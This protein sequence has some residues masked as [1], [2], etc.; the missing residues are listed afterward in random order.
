MITYLQYFDINGDKQYFDKDDCSRVIDK[1]TITNY[2]INTSTPEFDNLLETIFNNFFVEFE[3]YKKTQKIY[4]NS[5]NAVNA[6]NKLIYISGITAVILSALKTHVFK[7]EFGVFIK[8]S[9][10]AYNKEILASKTKKKTKPTPLY[11]KGF[12]FNQM[13]PVFDILNDLKYIKMYVGYNNKITANKKFTCF[14]NYYPTDKLIKL[15][16]KTPLPKLITPVEY[17][18]PLKSL[19]KEPVILRDNDKNDMKILKSS[20]IVKP[21]IRFLDKFNKFMKKAKISHVQNMFQW[22]HKTIR[23][24]RVFNNSSWSKGGR[25]YGAYQSEN[26]QNNQRQNILI[27]GEKTIEIDYQNMHPRMLYHLNGINPLGDL[28][29]IDRPEDRNHWKMFFQFALNCKSEL[30]TENALHQYFYKKN[31]HKKETDKIV[32]PFEKRFGDDWKKVIISQMKTKYNDIKHELFCNGGSKLQ[33]LDS[34]IMK[35]ALELL[36]KEGIFAIPF[37][38]S[39]VVQKKHEVKLRSIMMGCYYDTMKYFPVLK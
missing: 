22:R 34:K 8:R 37:H 26:N 4:L 9:T 5:S 28:Y 29:L 36:M 27:N 38:D 21:M 24:H 14:S 18:K 2:V 10:Q 17:T 31:K 16:E 11:E 30:L 23:L 39:I 6:K 33:N 19:I 15:F 12:K 7:T 25:F 13:I 3:N 32:N 20:E 35:N 1:N